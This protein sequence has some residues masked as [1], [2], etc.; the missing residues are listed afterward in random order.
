MHKQPAYGNYAKGT[1]N[2]RFVDIETLTAT[3][4]MAFFKQTRREIKV[5]LYLQYCEATKKTVR[6]M[7]EALN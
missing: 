7:P 3:L 5:K 4:N 1:D 2:R 6:K